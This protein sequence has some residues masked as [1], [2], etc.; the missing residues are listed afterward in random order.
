MKVAIHMSSPAAPLQLI[1]D[2]EDL[3]YFYR[4]R[5][6]LI[7]DFEDLQYFYRERHHRWTVW[8][9]SLAN[10]GETVLE[11][12]EIDAGTTAEHTP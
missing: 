3:L 5:H 12:Q 2:F 10:D 4:E 11:D 6:Q 1:V 8:R 7:V 9:T